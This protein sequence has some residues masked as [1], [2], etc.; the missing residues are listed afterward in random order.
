M[1]DRHRG[2][3]GCVNSWECDENGHLN[4]RF[5]VAKA[6]EALASF[7]AELGLPAGLRL[8]ETLQHM[9]FLGEA[10]P[11]A[12]LA[13]DV[14]VITVPAAPTE[15]LGLLL[16]VVSTLDDRV[17]AA[18][19]TDAVVVD[20][21]GA[22][23]PL[24]A[25]ARA[26]A[27]QYL[28]PLPAHAAP[29]GIPAQAPPPGRDLALAR[30][31]GMFEISKGRVAIGQCDDDGFMETFQYVGRISDGIVNMLARFQGAD[32][33]RARSEGRVG[34]AVVEYRLDYRRRPRAGDLLTV[35]TGVVA[36]QGRAHRIAHWLFDAR[37][38]EGLCWAEAVAVTLDLESRRA[39]DMPAEQHARMAQYLIPELVS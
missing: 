6:S 13:V 5:F 33:L 2:F 4:V 39:I 17:H 28:Q 23:A 36:L 9:R 30:R 7:G 25:D 8:R 26:R 24:S 37:S 31:L 29:R 1:T 3:L 20:Q 14:S 11:A 34:G 10:R 32:G 22:V 15:P 27:A 35:R 16:E 19:L 12:P 21:D 38:G 18:L